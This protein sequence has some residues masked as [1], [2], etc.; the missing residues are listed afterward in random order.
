MRAY[1]IPNIQPLVLNIHYNTISDS[2]EQTLETADKMIRSAYPMITTK[3]M[4]RCSLDS[5]MCF[6]T[7]EILRRRRNCTLR[8]LHFTC[9]RVMT[10]TKF[11]FENSC[12]SLFLTVACN[13]PGATESAALVYEPWAPVILRNNYV[14]RTLSLDVVFARKRNRTIISAVHIHLTRSHPP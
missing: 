5:G 14:T 6:R 2:V 9:R 1:R 7:V 11:H 8:S 4:V 13:R 3:T 10:D 12:M